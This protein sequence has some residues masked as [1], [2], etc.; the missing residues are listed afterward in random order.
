M[1]IL[2]LD[3]VMDLLEEECVVLTEKDILISGYSCQ[4]TLHGI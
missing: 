3:L 4:A 1:E 2:L